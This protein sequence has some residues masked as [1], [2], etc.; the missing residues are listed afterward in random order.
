M[1]AAASIE[2]N[3]PLDASDIEVTQNLEFAG[4][5]VK[6]LRAALGHLAKLAG[7]DVVVY[8]AS[9]ILLGENDKEDFERC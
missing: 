2:L 6:R 5:E 7:I 4:N 8:D 3:K 1:G 9:D